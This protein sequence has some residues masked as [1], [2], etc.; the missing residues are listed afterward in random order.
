MYATASISSLAMLLILVFAVV[1]IVFAMRR[2]AA[3]T[4]APS[5]VPMHSEFLESAKKKAP[6][7]A[8]LMG[9]LALALLLAVTAASLLIALVKYRPGRSIFNSTWVGLDNFDKLTSHA[10]FSSAISNSLLL[11]LAQLLGGLFVGLPLTMLVCLPR[12]RPGRVLTLASLCLMPA[13]L[14]QLSLYHLAI[15]ALPRQMLLSEAGVYVTF[16]LMTALPTGGFFAFC[17]G[18][19]AYMKRR[20]IGKGAGQGLLVALLIQALSLLSPDLSAIYPLANGVTANLST[21]LD[22]YS[23]QYGL[24]R[25]NYGMSAAASNIKVVGQM[26]LGILP[27]VMLCRIAKVDATRIDLPR[28]K[29]STFTVMLAPLFWAVALIAAIVI[30]VRYAALSASED[31]WILAFMKAAVSSSDS[32]LKALMQS[33]LIALGGGLLAA[34]A[35]YGIVY[36]YRYG[37]KSFGVAMLLLASSLTC[38]MSEYVLIRE[39][40]LINTV[41]A[42]MLRTLFDPRFIALLLVMT[43]LLRMAPERA[44]RGLALTLFLVA[45]SCAWSDYMSSYIYIMDSSKLSISALYYRQLVGMF[46][47]SSNV[48]DQMVLLQH[49]QKSV[50]MVLT[51]LPALMLS[52]LAALQ[53]IRCFRDAKPVTEA[54]MDVNT[55]ADETN[56][57][58]NI[59]PAVASAA[60][61]ILPVVAAVTEDIAPAVATV[62]ETVMPVIAAAT[63]GVAPVV[64]TAAEAVIPAVAAAIKDAVSE[65]DTIEDTGDA[66]VDS[67]ADIS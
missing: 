57:A 41:L 18:L 11:K 65:A 38:L 7:I 42:P 60:E 31:E 39:L 29:R 59:V 3:K 20:G 47:Q 63:E 13:L 52:L 16:A 9:N 21:T 23:F 2:R 66:P 33:V 28:A 44:T 40:G 10:L 30:L 50:S 37:R 22:V 1:L 36:K 6:V 45:A 46:S 62:A 32:L 61:T 43:I 48:T 27:A 24:S 14:P 49:A 58:E 54:D 4:P 8:R 15:T 67:P 34:S 12:K 5:E 53:C 19:F 26:L 56:D 35:G 51:T 25:G 64:A 55:E 17:G